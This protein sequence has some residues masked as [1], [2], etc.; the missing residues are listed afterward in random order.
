MVAEVVSKFQ[1]TS[2]YKDNVLEV[3]M[4]LLPPLPA[5]AAQDVGEAGVQLYLVPGGHKLSGRQ[6]GRRM[7]NGLMED[8]WKD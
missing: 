8:G 1:E 6:G 3:R 5:V 7:D 4:F 2:G